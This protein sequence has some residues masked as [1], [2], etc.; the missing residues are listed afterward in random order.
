[1]RCFFHLAQTSKLFSV[2]YNSWPGGCCTG[3]RE[4]W[5]QVSSSNLYGAI[6]R[7][8]EA[9]SPIFLADIICIFSCSVVVVSVILLVNILACQHAWRAAADHTPTIKTTLSSD[10]SIRFFG[11]VYTTVHILPTFKNQKTPAA[12]QDSSL[13]VRR[14]GTHGQPQSSRIRLA[15][16]SDLSLSEC[17]WTCALLAVACMPVRHGFPMLLGILKVFSTSR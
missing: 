1:M 14:A 12:T 11:S 7:P 6:P 2:I 17:M 4:A 10:I 15:S 16:Y 13:V 8:P 9:I 3:P 5:R